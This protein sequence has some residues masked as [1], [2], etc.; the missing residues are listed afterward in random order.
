MATD[1]LRIT[2]D[3]HSDFDKLVAEYKESGTIVNG[4]LTFEMNIKCRFD[5]V[6]ALVKM[7]GNQ[8]SDAPK[9]V[10]VDVMK[11]MD[12]DLTIFRFDT[13]EG[14]SQKKVPTPERKVYKNIFFYIDDV[15]GPGFYVKNVKEVL[16]G[17]VCPDGLVEK[18]MGIIQDHWDRPFYHIA[19]SER[20]SKDEGD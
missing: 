10:G 13:C 4:V 9:V 16:S 7:V 17:F 2:Y 5:R 8:P 6:P 11:G 1:E 18:M 19:K 14:L 15:N 3:P 12:I 20:V